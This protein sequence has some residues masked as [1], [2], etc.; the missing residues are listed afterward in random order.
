MEEWEGS[1]GSSPPPHVL[2]VGGTGGG[3]EG[4]SLCLEPQGRLRKRRRGQCHTARGQASV[5][6]PCGGQGARF[7]AQG[8]VSLGTDTWLRGPRQQ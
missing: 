3:G 6:Q 4:S 1:Q 8:P 7:R 2:A 5:T